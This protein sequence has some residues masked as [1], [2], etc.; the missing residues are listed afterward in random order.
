M[1]V[2]KRELVHRF[3]AG[4]YEIYRELVVA[5]PLFAEIWQDGQDE[6]TR[7]A[8]QDC[9]GWIE[10]MSGEHVW[11]IQVYNFEGHHIGNPDEARLL[12]FRYGTLRPKHTQHLSL[13]H[14]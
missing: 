13:I 10:G 11:T 14:I 4:R 6:E 12:W 8:V 7:Q 3:E 2:L 5:P 9:V 1:K